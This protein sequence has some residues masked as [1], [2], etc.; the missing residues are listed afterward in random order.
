MKLSASC[1]SHLSPLPSPLSI[2]VFPVRI[3][4]LMKKLRC[5]EED[6]KEEEGGKEGKEEE[7]KRAEAKAVIRQGLCVKAGTNPPPLHVLLL[8]DILLP[9]T[10]SSSLTPSSLAHPHPPLHHPTPS[11]PQTFSLS[12]LSIVN[13]RG[14]G[15]LRIS[16][17]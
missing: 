6:R 8:P 11:H 15:L 4:S 10:S 1:L 3:C 14:L 2:Q 16:V 7:A 9:Y 13:E 12:W 5:K 17:A